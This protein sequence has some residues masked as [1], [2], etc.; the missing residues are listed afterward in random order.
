MIR[1][2]D[3]IIRRTRGYFYQD[4]LVEMLLGVLFL[5]VGLLL[6]VWVTLQ[7]DS[8][9][10]LLMAIGLPVLVIGGVV[11]TQI[12]IRHLKERV[13]YPR[14]GF[15]SYGEKQ[16]S[17]IRWLFTVVPLALIVLSL[18]LPQW[19]SQMAWFEGA[20]LGLALL[21]IGTRA[22][23]WRFYLLAGLSLLIGLVATVMTSGDLPGTALTFSGAGLALLISGVITFRRYLRHHPKPFETKS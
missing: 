4:G 8:P 6:Q 18:L 17:R 20:M 12:A 13:T 23:L 10:N 14:T 7:S 16:P 19:F 21:I 3:G 11:Y 2:L 22:G 15:A 9:W 5:V 1:N